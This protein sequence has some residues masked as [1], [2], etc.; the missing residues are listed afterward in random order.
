[1]ITTRNLHP[2]RERPD[3]VSDAVPRVNIMSEAS[4]ATVSGIP[5]RGLWPSEHDSLKL[6]SASFML[7]TPSSNGM[8]SGAR[9]ERARRPGIIVYEARGLQSLL[10]FPKKKTPDA[11]SRDNVFVSRAFSRVSPE[12]LPWYRSRSVMKSDKIGVAQDGTP[13]HPALR[14]NFRPSQPVNDAG[15][16]HLAPLEL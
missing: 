16:S 4:G 8:L 6:T 10:L 3:G 14:V 9:G 1:M 5:I 11:G 13:E 12:Q 7:R 2:Y 15:R